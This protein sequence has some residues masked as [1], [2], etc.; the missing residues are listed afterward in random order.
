MFFFRQ[1][2]IILSSVIRFWHYKLTPANSAFYLEQI[3]KLVF[4]TPWELLRGPEGLLDPLNIFQVVF[5]ALYEYTQ[6]VFKNQRFF[7]LFLFIQPNH[8]KGTV[9]TDQ[10]RLIR[11]KNKPSFIYVTLDFF[12]I[13]PLTC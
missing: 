11:I 2:I 4:K 6:A 9:S 10:I 8:F 3:S 5:G 13:L 1:I 12:H 7:F